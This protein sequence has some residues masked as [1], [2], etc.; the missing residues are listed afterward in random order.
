MSDSMTCPNGIAWCTRKHEQPD[1]DGE[2]IY[3]RHSAVTP[4]AGGKAGVRIDRLD[5]IDTNGITPGDLEVTV[6]G[7]GDDCALNATETGELATTLVL[8][9]AAL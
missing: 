7:A 6:L 4:V 8:V 1:H 2:A 5:V 3:V 9:T